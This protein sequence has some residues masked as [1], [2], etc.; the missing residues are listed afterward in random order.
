MS[1]PSGA[2]I[3]AGPIRLEQR[4]DHPL[5]MARPLL[6]V[7]AL[8]QFL[9]R[10]RYPEVVVSCMFQIWRAHVSRGR[11]QDA[12]TVISGK[13]MEA[14][15]PAILNSRTS[16]AS[17]ACIEQL[18]VTPP[19]N[20]GWVPRDEAA[21]S[22]PGIDG[23]KKEQHREWWSNM[24]TVEWIYHSNED[25]YFHLPSNSLWERRE[26]ECCDPVAG[27]HTYCR[28]DAV[29]L[30][31]LSHFAKTMDTALVPMAWKAWVFY[32]RRR[33]G[34]HSVAQPPLAPIEEGPA[35]PAS[36]ETKESSRS[37][38]T[39][40]E[41][42][43][44]RPSS[45]ATESAQGAPAAGREQGSPDA[46]A[47]KGPSGEEK[48]TV[49]LLAVAAAGV[50][51]LVSEK[52]SP[53]LRTGSSKVGMQSTADSSELAKALPQTLADRAEDGSLA[54]EKPRGC[55]LCFRIR[56]RSKVKCS[57]SDSTA[58]ELPKGVPA[59]VLEKAAN[60]A[61]GGA[62]RERNSSLV[63]WTEEEQP[64][65][66]PAKQA[67][68]L[69]CETLERHMRRLELFLTEVKRNPQRLVTHVERRR[70]EKTHVAFIV[71]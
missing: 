52:K 25:K 5:T 30:Q 6:L 51:K 61:A 63:S 3:A 31:A 19:P 46:A 65:P 50:D 2:D 47:G 39:S 18:G 53:F 34:R 62:A 33:T 41:H 1:L 17:F 37:P 40:N 64:E 16:A 66:A 27:P 42:P 55:C 68:Q 28:V 36:K 58:C 70:A 8:W 49:E 11:W 56:G 12:A 23:L 48:A 45:L 57:T 38:H 9:E 4:I 71:L 22:E 15:A 67:P 24:N 32:W 26:T 10:G 43:A 7:I 35:E 54:G 29:H 59:E 60:T 20:A 13:D 14:Q 21:E 44:Q 69:N